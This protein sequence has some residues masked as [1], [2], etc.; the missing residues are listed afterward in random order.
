M[1][2]LVNSQGIWTLAISRN[3]NKLENPTPVQ[4]EQIKD[5]K[6][7]ASMPLLVFLSLPLLYPVLDPLDP[8]QSVPS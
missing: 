8:Q 1:V 4:Q 2:S 7:A 3:K 6:H 5:C